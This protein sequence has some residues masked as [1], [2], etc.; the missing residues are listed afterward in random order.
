LYYGS[1]EEKGG[2]T[3]K[4]FGVTSLNAGLVVTIIVK[5]SLKNLNVV[6]GEDTFKEFP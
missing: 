2:K 4:D 5:V 6:T 1:A 3:I